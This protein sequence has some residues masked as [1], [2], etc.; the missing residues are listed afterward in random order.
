MTIN[1]YVGDV[2]EYLSKVAKQSDQLAKLI[3]STNYQNLSDGTYYTSIGDLDHII[4]FGKILQQ[5]DNI[6]YVEPTRWSSINIKKWTECYLLAFF[7]A[8]NKIIHG[9]QIN[10]SEHKS[11]MLELVDTRKTSS[12]QIWNAGCSITFGTGID[13]SQRYGKLIGD[14]FNLPVSFL[15]KPG[16]SIRWQADQ[17]LRSNIKKGDLLIWGLTSIDRTIQWNQSR[18]VHVHRTTTDDPRLI[19][20]LL[21][22]QMMY[23]AVGYIHQV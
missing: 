23:D 16:T 17:I 9:F 6:F 10:K 15:T 5:S 2:A 14:H 18:L 22:D 8:N 13:E 1:V 20:Q 21:S 3:D 4:H 11:V 7:Y 12:V 19:E